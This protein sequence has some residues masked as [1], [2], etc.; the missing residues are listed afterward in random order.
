MTST[1]NPPPPL[2]RKKMSEDSKIPISSLNFSHLRLGMKVTGLPNMTLKKELP[3]VTT[4]VGTCTIQTPYDRKRQA[5]VQV[6]GVSP[7]NW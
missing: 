7:K 5:S 6:C 4:S 3:S 2:Q 1:A